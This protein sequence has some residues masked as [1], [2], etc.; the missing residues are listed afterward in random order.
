MLEIR[1]TRR[2]FAGS[3]AAAAAAFLARPATAA[4]AAPTGSPTPSSVTP[5]GAGRDIRLDSN[6]NPYGPP[7]SAV[8][9][10]AASTPAAARYPDLHESP[11]IDDLA[12]HHGVAPANILLGCGSGEILKMADMAFLGEG[13]KVV[14]A[15]PTFEAVLRFAGLA[16]AL[17]VKVPL[18]GDFRHDLEAMAAAC[19]KQT[20]LVYVCNPNNPTGTIVSSQALA[21]FLGTVPRQTVVLVDEAYHHFVDD[22][23]YGSAAGWI[24]KYPNLVVARTFSKIYGLAGMRLGYAIAA[25]ERIDALQPQAVWS[26]G[27]VAVLEAARACLADQ[28]QVARTRRAMNDTRDWL[29]G[30]LGKDGRR[31]IPS[32]ANFVMIDLGTDV[33]PVR[34]ALAARG[35]HVGRRFPSMAQWLR[36]SIGTP[37]ETAAFL[38]A[39]RDVAPAAGKS[40]KA[41]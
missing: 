39:L 35:I 21:A 31:I 36:V 6:E 28:A 16:H 12:R 15:E 22:P 20:G 2:H 8:R 13:Q 40:D 9:A 5:T 41:A 11:L 29:C 3:L 14:A 25:K 34:D 24:G 26:N 18:T 19:D 17:A 7:E 10:M 27:N 33:Q 4:P 23:A 37:D 38:A 30:E 32:E 1:L